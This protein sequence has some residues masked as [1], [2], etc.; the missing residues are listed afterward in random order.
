MLDCCSHLDGYIY[1]IF[2]IKNYLHYLH[3]L[4]YCSHLG[5][6]IIVSEMSYSYWQ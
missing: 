2:E 3:N 6:Y 4:D 5:Y 1:N